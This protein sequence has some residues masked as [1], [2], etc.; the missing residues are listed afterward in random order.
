MT[1][2]GPQIVQKTIITTEGGDGR[3]SACKN[4]VIYLRFHQNE[5]L[6]RFSRRR[7]LDD[8]FT[9]SHMR[10]TLARENFTSARRRR[11]ISLSMLKV[12]IYRCVTP[13]FHKR[14]P[15]QP[16]R[17]QPFDLDKEVSHFIVWPNETWVELVNVAKDEWL[18]IDMK[19]CYPASFQGEGEAKPYYEIKGSGTR[20]TE[21][22]GRQSMVHCQHFSRKIPSSDSGVVW[23]AVCG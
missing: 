19:S 1:S 16:G 22:S 13:R 7:R 4:L 9:T 6:L 18:C 11:A 15:L 3:L 21:W 5:N 23:K 20:Q 2:S 14:W 10:R 8:V 12:P 17:G